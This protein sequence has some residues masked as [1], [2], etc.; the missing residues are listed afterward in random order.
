MGGSD[1]Q[2]LLVVCRD[3]GIYPQYKTLKRTIPSSALFFFITNHTKIV[4]PVRFRVI[5]GLRAILKYNNI[6]LSENSN[7][8]INKFYAWS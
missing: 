1:W 6:L 4:N 3:E 5:I 2:I 8:K 7:Y